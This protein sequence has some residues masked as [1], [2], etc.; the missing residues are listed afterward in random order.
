MV[1]KIVKPKKK[2]TKKPKVD[3]VKQANAKNKA[4]ATKN[5]EPWIGVLST[6][7]DPKNP[8]SGYFELDWNKYFIENNVKT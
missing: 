8:K 7:F 3:L 1:K 5:K 6:Q 2:P 4:L